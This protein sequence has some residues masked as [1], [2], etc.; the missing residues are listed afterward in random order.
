MVD[1]GVDQDLARDRLR[2]SLGVFA[3]RLDR[4]IVFDSS[5][6]IAPATDPFGRSRGYRLV[7]GGTSRG[8]EITARIEP[9]RWIRASSSYAYTHAKPPTGNPADLPQ[10]VA[11]PRHQFVA[12][13][14]QTI[15]R[16]IQ[17]SIDITMSGSYVAPISDR[18][19]FVSRTY[20]FHGIRRIDVGASYRR[21]LSSRM[22]LRLFGKVNNLTGQ[23]Y[24]ESGFRNPGRVLQIGTTLEF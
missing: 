9:F 11:I 12:T 14:L 8:V 15:S 18:D 4:T 17:T 5:G 2:L 6:V 10:A 13:A 7:D 21:P 19:T 22:S 1:A 23:A 20:R 24:F 3:T 16:S